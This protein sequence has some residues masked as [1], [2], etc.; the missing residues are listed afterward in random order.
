MRK[1]RPHM[2]THYRNGDAIRMQA[3]GCDGCSPSRINGVFC[4]ETGC[5]DAWRDQKIECAECGAKFYPEWRSA[6]RLNQYCPDCQ[7]RED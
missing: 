5:P 7:G 6:W 4:H 2:R 3:N 1:I